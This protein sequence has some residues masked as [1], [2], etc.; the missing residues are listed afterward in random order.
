MLQLHNLKK[1]T[2]KRKR[3]GRGGDRG[4]LSGRGRDGQKGA[5]GSTS[6]IS[7]TFEGGQITLVRRIPRRGLIM[8]RL[9]KNIILLSWL[10]WTAIAI[11]TKQLIK[12]L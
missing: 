1:L 9:E 5:T 12:T 6:E 11:R 4:G 2:K 8:P 3:I 7:A 10:I